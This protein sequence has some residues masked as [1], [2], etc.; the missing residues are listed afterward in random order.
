MYV[1]P[2]SQLAG[3]DTNIFNLYEGT[4]PSNSQPLYFVI[5]DTNSR[6]PLPLNTQMYSEIGSNG[7]GSPVCQSIPS[8]TNPS[9]NQ[10]Y[11]SITQITPDISF[12]IALPCLLYTSDAA[13]E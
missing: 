4:N 10:G 8:G 1:Y 13:D 2:Q 11:I 9:D 6:N 12:P 3:G 7:N 5:S